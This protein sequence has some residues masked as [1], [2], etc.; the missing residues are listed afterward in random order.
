[1][2]SELKPDKINLTEFPENNEEKTKVII[3]T[4]IGTDW[5]D[6]MAIIYA[7]HIPNLEILGITTNYG[8][9][10]LRAGVTQKI[11]DAYI[12]NNPEKNKIPVISGASQPLG[13]HRELLIY[14]HEGLPFFERSVLKN[15][16]NMKNI[17]KREQQN[18]SK[19]IV[20]TVKK[21]PNQVKIISIG[22]PTNI[23]LALKN[24]KEII[25]LIKEIV[26]MGCGSFIKKDDLNYDPIN[27]VKNGKIINL[28]PNHNVSG[29]SMASKIL[30]DACIPTK[31]I[32]H[33][34]SSKFW[35]EG[36]VIEFLKEKAN[37]IKDIKNPENPEGA[38]GLLMKEWFS[39]RRQNGQ[40]PHDPLTVNEA[41]FGGEKSPIIYARG[42]IISHEWAAFST[43]IPQE[44]GPHYLGI[45]V[46]KDNKF[47]E[48]LA[49]TIMN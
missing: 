4:D 40:C 12:K 41:V 13:T 34:V 26:I 36:P 27:E 20:S 32:S 6:A 39:I 1:M 42:R 43:F 49:N 18:A 23:G 22:I 30:F 15:A 44:N 16:L 35:S 5:D 11:I 14:G 31:I 24:N 38:V 3:D 25:P 8:I 7:L 47:L 28:Y 29:D 19:F 9:P 46:K 45:D 10:D 48:N 33:S 17:T 2:I 37:N 21:Y